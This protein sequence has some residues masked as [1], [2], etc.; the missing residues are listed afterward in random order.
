MSV[1][2]T[3]IHQRKIPNV[4]GYSSGQSIVLNTVVVTFLSLPRWI[5]HENSE[6]GHNEAACKCEGEYSHRC[7][8]SEML[9]SAILLSIEEVL[10]STPFA[11]DII[12]PPDMLTFIEPL[13]LPAARN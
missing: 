8:E 7:S 9:E 11:R 1:F 6:S 5:L 2:D 12:P 13:P 10:I 3:L 4:Q